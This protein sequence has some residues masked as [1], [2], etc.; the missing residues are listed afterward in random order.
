MK[1]QSP[2]QLKLYINRGSRPEVFCKKGI[3]RPVTLVKKSLQ[4]RC[5]PVN[6]AK[7][8]RT[9]FLKNTSG[10]CFCTKSLL[11]ITAD[12]WLMRLVFLWSN[13]ILKSVSFSLSSC[14]FFAAAIFSEIFRAR[15]STV[16]QQYLYSST[17]MSRL[18]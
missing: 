13:N 5:F 12:K 15:T 3:P 6:F 2:C 4:H 14:F 1:C 16:V 9:P 10:G 8:L 7:F 18:I 11:H 17:E